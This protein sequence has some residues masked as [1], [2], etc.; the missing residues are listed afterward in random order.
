MGSIVYENGGVKRSDVP[1]SE[2]ISTENPNGSQSKVGGSG[3]YDLL[4]QDGHTAQA[5][6]LQKASGQYTSQ[7]HFI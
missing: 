2:I 3:Y 6:A 4:R 1:L 5:D 7:A